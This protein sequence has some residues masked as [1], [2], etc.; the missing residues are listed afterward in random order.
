MVI[1]P[2]APDEVDAGS[3]EDASQNV[4]E[5]L[6]KMES[7]SVRDDLV[8][9]VLDH[10]AQHYEQVAFFALKRDRLVLWRSRVDGQIRGPG[11]RAIP[12]SG[13]STFADVVRAA[14]PFQGPLADHDSRA[15]VAETMNDD[16]GPCLLLPVT[17][18]GR[19]VGILYGGRGT[20]AAYEEHLALVLRALGDALERVVLAA[21][22]SR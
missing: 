14:L 18:R 6:R 22:Q 20:R 12:L 16:D 5:T 11:D 15:M 4:L 3:M 8:L 1:S 2:V 21:K 13:D 19:L 7:L 17:V 9:C 10:L